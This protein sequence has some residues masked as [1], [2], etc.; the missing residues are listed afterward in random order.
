L[1]WMD[2]I[3]ED[4]FDCDRPSKLHQIGEIISK[5]QTPSRRRAELHKLPFITE[6]L[7]KAFSEKKM[8][9]TASVSSRYMCDAIVAFLNGEIYGNFQAEAL[10]RKSEKQIHSGEEKAAILKPDILNNDEI[11]D[12][13]VVFRAIN[14]TRKVINAIINTYGSPEYII[15]E[16][17]SDL[18]RSFSDRREITKKQK[19]NEAENDAIKK[20]IAEILNISTEEVSGNDVDKYKLYY[21]QSGKCMYSGEDLGDILEV[22]GDKGRRYEVDHIIPYSMILDNTLQNKALVF[23]SQNQFKGQRTPLMFLSGNCA[24]EFVKRVNFMYTRKD[25]PISKKKYEYYMLKDLYGPNA[26][27]ML[28]DWKSRNINDTRYITKYIVSLLAN[29]LIFSGKAQRP[30]CGIKGALTSKFRRI[31]LNDKTWGNK[32]KNRD[33]YLNHAVDAVVIAN[34]TPAYVEIASDN[35][36]LQQIFRR[37]RRRDIPEYEDYLERCIKKMKKYY[38]FSEEYT[39]TL[40][41][42][43]QRVPSYVP[44]LQYEVD[45]RFNSTDPDLFEKK[46]EE[47]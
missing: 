31:W 22:L 35:I 33:T 45:I 29:S 13:P 24:E 32:E 11:K 41:M 4:Q 16:V 47:L 2:F 37:F 3:N 12:N 27:E 23:G 40:L 19:K 18:N 39:R 17:A 9:G 5:Y 43:T 44:N 8:S 7:E 36:K 46:I 15:V 25:K 26:E 38:G 30:V 42:K 14:E 21:E 1:S 6:E 28:G 10:K 20:K 34:L